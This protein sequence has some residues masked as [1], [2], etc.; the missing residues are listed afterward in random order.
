MPDEKGRAFVTKVFTPLVGVCASQDAD[1]LARLNNLPSFADFLQPFGENMNAKVSVTDSQ[2]HASTLDAFSIRFINMNQLDRFDANLVNKVVG[3][4]L[5][6]SEDAKHKFPEVRSKSNVEDVYGK[7]S[8]DTLTP[9]YAAYRNF[10]C[11][12]AGFSEHDTLN[13][14][15]ACLIV[16][17]TSNSDPIGT[18]A[19]FFRDG[20]LPTAYERGFLDPAI[21]KHYLLLH[22][23]ASAPGVDADA[24][25]QQLKQ[26]V[27]MTAC[28]M[29]KI[30]SI[31]HPPVAEALDPFSPV[32]PPPPVVPDIWFP[33]QEEV[34][35]LL[36]KLKSGLRSGSATSVSS[37]VTSPVN[38]DGFPV[39]RERTSTS[40][41]RS[42][43]EAALSSVKENNAPPRLDPLGILG[44]GAASEPTLSAAPVVPQLQI[45]QNTYGNYLNNDD[46]N[47]FEGF[48]REFVTQRVLKSMERNIQVWNEETASNRKGVAARLGRVMNMFSAK[49]RTSTPSPTPTFDRAGVAI[50]P[51]NGPEFTMRRLADYSFMLRDY[52]FAYSTYDIVRKDFQA[53]DKYIKFLAG[54]QEMLGLCTLL[55]TDIGRNSVNG[56]HEA[57]VGGYMEAKASNFAARTA[58]LYYEMLAEREQYRDAPQLLIRMTGEDSDLRSAIFLEQ[59]ALCFLRFRPAMVR[60]YA[61]HLILAG[62]R[63]SKCNQR[64]HA[65][66]CYTSALD[67]YE[68]LGW[69]L[70]E[71][72]A[73]YTLGRQSFYLGDMA[74]TVSFF[75]KLLRMSR[76]PVA[77][78]AAYL[79]EFLYI[80]KQFAARATPDDIAK[81]PPLPIPTFKDS[82]VRV[83]LLEGQSTSLTPET[84]PDEEWERME[85][86][87]YEE[88]YNKSPILGRKFTT[89]VKETAGLL[90]GGKTHCA[91][92]EPVFVTV[93]VH[94]PMQIPV[95][96]NN[97]FSE[98]ASEGSAPAGSNLL[99]AERASSNVSYAQFD[100]EVIPEISLNAGE[101][102]TLQLRV[103]P[104][105]EGTLIIH[106]VRYNFAGTVPTHHIFHKRGRRLNDPVSMK[107]ETPKYAADHTLQLAVTSPMPVLDVQFQSFPESLLS[108]E[109]TKAVLQISNKGNRGLRNLRLKISHPSFLRVGEG[110]DLDGE[111]YVV[112]TGDGIQSY[113]TSNTLSDTS[114]IVIKLAPDGILAAGATTLVPIWVRGDRIGK[115]VFRF[116]FGYQSE[117]RTD[118]VSCRTL[119]YAM[120]V[121]VLASLRINAFT[122]PSA[123][124]LDEFI[125]GIEIENL[126]ASTDFVLTQISSLSS[127]WRIQK[128]GMESDQSDSKLEARQ[129]TF[130]YF[131]FTRSNQELDPEHTPE[132]LTTKAIERLIVGAED[133]PLGA[134]D[135]TLDVASLSLVQGGEIVNCAQQPLH[136][137]TYASRLHWRSTQLTT[138]HPT[139]NFSQLANLFTLYYTDDVDLS[140]FWH[141]TGPDGVQHRGH[142]YIIGINLALQS[143]LPLQRLT[144]LAASK[145]ASKALFAETV[146]EK[147]AVVGSLLKTKG[148]DISPVRIVT[149]APVEV[150]WRFGDGPCVLPITISIHNSSRVNDAQYVL[151]MLVPGSTTESVTS[152]KSTKGPAGAAGDFSWLGKT[153]ASSTL[154]PEGEATETVLAT[155]ARPGVYDLNQWKLSTTIG[156]EGGTGTV[157]GS[158]VQSPNLPHWLS[159]L[160]G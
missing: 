160:N 99:S 117:D 124:S 20:N 82:S 96:L 155:F 53:S 150:K 98:C 33:F 15:V 1:D 49:Q 128:L 22:D 151:E 48:I 66:R 21:L 133:A 81:F 101:H 16:V 159:V 4:H 94:N 142:H 9:W 104:K 131:R 24:V 138:Q 28:H 71:D 126:Q 35:K 145:G 154:S 146:R 34:Q 74:G 97:V 50:F 158:Y 120:T 125:L 76:Q 85:Q 67:V 91:V 19:Q 119:R 7:E 69:T 78:Q 103:F 61:F 54:V 10:T 2:G 136:G 90:P 86:E 137:L 62:H 25:F 129:T 134:K 70:V 123:R 14:P 26:T 83:S 113:Q 59:A 12:Y 65:Y 38:D 102:R 18:A 153:F 8:L 116:L 75:L 68:G 87:L 88:G 5:R 39:L 45:P 89:G 44:P 122:R 107:S 147:K 73:H 143:P 92:G 30:N 23:A 64:E 47:S 114:T 109:V 79:K 51:Y 42:S 105:Q 3:D 127:M 37:A 27:G 36:E 29:L 43:F 100:A 56:Y 135:L 41:E 63:Y 152:T 58:V 72:H 106:G 144:Q 139:L 84:L 13:H 32:T 40:I 121:N 6:E 46:M 140:L 93:E 52:K 57:A 111:A 31:P 77:Q 60:K 95:H 55:T 115:H 132:V 17:S 130:V 11:K 110:G 141:V 157:V 156:G 148:K 118:K 149:R 80:Y 108:G 112:A